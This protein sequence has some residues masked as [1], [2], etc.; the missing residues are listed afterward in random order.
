MR[1]HVALGGIWDLK[2]SWSGRESGAEPERTWRTELRVVGVRR[3]DCRMEMIMAG[4]TFSSV[5]WYLAMLAR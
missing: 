5:I 1:L 2:R 4:T 3:L